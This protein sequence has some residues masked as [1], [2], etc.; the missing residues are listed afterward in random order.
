MWNRIQRQNVRPSTQRRTFFT[1]FFST[2][3]GD[4]F[5]LIYLLFVGIY[6]SS[7]PPENYWYQ[8]K[9]QKPRVLGRSR[10][11]LRS[12]PSKPLWWRG[13]GSSAGSSRC[14]K[15]WSYGL[16]G[17]LPANRARKKAS[18]KGLSPQCCGSIPF[19]GRRWIRCV[20]AGRVWATSRG[21]GTGRS[22]EADSP[23]TPGSCCV[24]PAGFPRE[25]L[26]W[27]MDINH[28]KVFFFFNPWKDKRVKCNW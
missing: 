9:L 15:G 2:K 28:V 16:E 5:L 7:M 27:L 10:S 22:G 26:A 12:L 25:H 3:S 6:L 19:R 17:Q 14:L 1:P 24:T 11:I 18:G 20:G 13:Q 23:F 4:F 21:L 8:N